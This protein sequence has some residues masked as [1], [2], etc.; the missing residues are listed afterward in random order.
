MPTIATSSS[1]S[2]TPGVAGAAAELE[3]AGHHVT[4][5]SVSPD[6]RTEMERLIASGAVAGVL[7]LT[8]TDVASAALSGRTTNYLR[9]TGDR[10]LP[11]VVVPGGVD[12][13]PPGSRQ[14]QLHRTT[15]EENTAIATFIADRLNRYPFPPTVALPLGGIS[16]LST[17]GGPHHDPD[18]DH[19]LFATLTDKL[20]PDITVMRCN[21]SINHP[22]FA[23]LCARN[24]LDD[25]NT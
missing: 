2:T 1:D 23:Q 24:L 13:L 15:P 14:S 21:H 17:P 4:I 20:N 10:S 25:L 11:S 12:L 8:L 22:T 3:T 18:A 5:F 7:D 6:T 16:S 19:A 9:A